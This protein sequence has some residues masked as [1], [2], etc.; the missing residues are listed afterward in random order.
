MLKSLDET[1]ILFF[2]ISYSLKKKISVSFSLFTRQH[3]LNF[4]IHVIVKLKS[5]YY[6]YIYPVEKRGMLT[7]K[8]KNVNVY[9]FFF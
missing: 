2:F 5:F 3:I 8:D 6:M 1:M 7:L 9:F 4:D